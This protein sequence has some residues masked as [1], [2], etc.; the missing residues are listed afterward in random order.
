MTNRS[1][2]ILVAVAVVAGIGVAAYG[3]ATRGSGKS[4]PVLQIDEVN[5]RVGKVVLGESRENVIGVL[6]KPH[7]S[8]GVPIPLATPGPL[9][10]LLLYLHLL[11]GLR[12]NH[13]VSIWTDDP[14]AQTEKIVKIGD[15][16]SAVR[17]AYRKA[18]KCIPNAPDKHDPNPRCTVKVPAGSL[19]VRGDPIRAMTLTRTG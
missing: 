11:I 9:P 17:A 10:P 1:L 7:G 5:G 13:V 8:R 6:G 12:D 3:L 2:A 16:I 19:F 18:A 4:A 14:D 15:P